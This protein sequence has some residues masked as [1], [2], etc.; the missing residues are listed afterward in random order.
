MA[1]LL[2]FD[3]KPFESVLDFRE[4]K[5]RGDELDADQW[6]SG[7]LDI[8]ERVVNEVDRRLS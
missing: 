8:V 3:A 5:I 2:K 1:S 7:Y 6:F 4:K